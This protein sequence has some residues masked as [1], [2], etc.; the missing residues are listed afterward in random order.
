MDI[1]MTQKSSHS[2]AQMADAIHKPIFDQPTVSASS[3]QCTCTHLKSLFLI[4]LFITFPLQVT[5]A[6]YII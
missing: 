5:M 3:M 1:K 4:T 2:I 6:L